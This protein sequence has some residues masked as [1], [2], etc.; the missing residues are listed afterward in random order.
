MQGKN[1]WGGAIWYVGLN[2]S[3]DRNL[4][5]GNS[6]LFQEEYAVVVLRPQLSSGH[7]MTTIAQPWVP[8][9]DP[10]VREEFFSKNKALDIF[11][12]MPGTI[13][14][15]GENLSGLKALYQLIFEEEEKD[16]LKANRLF[17]RILPYFTAE[18]LKELSNSSSNGKRE[19]LLDKV[20]KAIE[21]YLTQKFGEEAKNLLSD[22]FSSY[23]PE[24][25]KK[26][27]DLIAIFAYLEDVTEERL[28]KA[29]LEE[30]K[31]SPLS[32]DD[33]GRFLREIFAL[34]PE[35]YQDLLEYA[36]YNPDFFPD[37]L[38]SPK[39]IAAYF[40]FANGLNPEMD[41]KD[42]I[43]AYD[44]FYKF[45]SSR[46]KEFWEQ[47]NLESLSQYANW[48]NWLNKNGG[49]PDS[50]KNFDCFFQFKD[51]FPN[52]P[53]SKISPEEV[54]SL[55]STILDAFRGYS[56]IKG[57]SF[58][59]FG[60]FLKESGFNK[61]N[62]YALNFIL[63]LT[64]GLPPQKREEKFNWYLKRIPNT[65][66]AGLGPYHLDISSLN[67]ALLLECS[68]LFFQQKPSPFLLDNI[69]KTYNIIGEKFNDNPESFLRKI[70]GFYRE[71]EAIK[72]TS[73]EAYSLERTKARA[74]NS[75][76]SYFERS[77]VSEEEIEKIYEEFIN[78][79]D[80]QKLVYGGYK[81]ALKELSDKDPS[82][83]R[84]AKKLF[85]EIGNFESNP[86]L[87]FFPDAD[88]W[89]EIAK[90]TEN[91][92]NED[93]A[94]KIIS[95]VYKTGDNFL[96]WEFIYSFSE[97]SENNPNFSLQINTFLDIISYCQSL[98]IPPPSPRLYL[99]HPEA[100]NVEFW[101]G[102]ER[103]LS[104]KKDSVFFD[105]KFIEKESLWQEKFTPSELEAVRKAWKTLKEDSK[106]PDLVKANL[107]LDTVGV[108]IESKVENPD[109]D[110][111]KALELLENIESS[112][113]T[114]RS[115]ATL[116][117]EQYFWDKVFNGKG[118]NKETLIEI[119]NLVFVEQPDLG[120]IYDCLFALDEE[121]SPEVL[122]KLNKYGNF[123]KNLKDSITE[124]KAAKEKD[125]ELTT[126][127]RK[128]LDAFT[129]QVAYR[130]FNLNT[131]AP[132]NTSLTSS[133]LL[134]LYLWAI[135]TPGFEK[136]QGLFVEYSAKYFL[137]D[138]ESEEEFKNYTREALRDVPPEDYLRPVKIRNLL[139][140]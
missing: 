83:I 26:E 39:K 67:K 65:L 28:S 98:D 91:F 4:V 129:L 19:L 59:Q 118:I 105:L 93:E 32:T 63:L 86:K 24:T 95:K 79:S 6:Q 57:G 45:V 115:L 62:I 94:I 15:T 52:L 49:F 29:L 88:L 104:E 71:I 8:T 27:G 84:L 11:Y 139:L 137:S 134:E 44:Q 120:K 80:S 40:E 35:H 22:I 50:Y 56:E 43:S 25:Q 58:F 14:E 30:I 69:L 16:I 34:S 42:K 9:F 126:T 112:E 1:E 48:V 31:N 85:A 78:L 92:P 23:Y 51:L 47:E 135:D 81:S 108:I 122:E 127:Q 90:I 123:Y 125:S 102:L 131:G 82:S 36:T 64:A 114:R 72:T 13:L 136:L 124:I 121:L 140:K 61:D 119:G 73:V 109:F 2:S 18:D 21:A 128:F 100:K 74:M 33:K 37:C 41:K 101:H 103:I 55:M 117:L 97:C 53:P 17:K 66:A 46:E 20:N 89:P 10:R 7:G 96:F 133:D 110:V 132:F 70:E 54:A 99:T 87:T 130:I 76:L 116:L 138:Q 68:D 3:A 107:F 77:D 75:L 38:K 113:E 5:Y 106:L 60:K 12:V 111:K